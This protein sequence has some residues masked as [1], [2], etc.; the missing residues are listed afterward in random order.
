MSARLRA[1]NP[2][3]TVELGESGTPLALATTDGEDDVASALVS[4]GSAASRLV[5]AIARGQTST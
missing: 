5:A 4:G 3:V 1:L 2:D